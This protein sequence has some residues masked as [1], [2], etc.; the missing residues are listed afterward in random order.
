MSRRRSSGGYAMLAALLV[1]VLA[2]AFALVVV[3]AVHAVQSVEGADAAARRATAAEGPALAALARSLRWRPSA[4]SG[5]GEG[6]DPRTVGA[7]RVSWTPEPAVAGDAW[8]RVAAQVVTSAGRARHRDD[9]V[10]D[11]RS[12]SWAIGVTCAADADIAAPLTVCGSGVYLG[13]CLRGREN[14]AFVAG[15][16][17]GS[18]A[19]DVRGDLFPAAAVH[20]GAGIFAR[21][22]EIHE[23]PS[24]LGEFPDDSDRHAGRSVPETWLAGPAVE[25]LLAAAVE[26]ATP[27]RALRG[28]V[29]RLDQLTSAGSG[30]L[31]GGRCLLLPQTDEVV[32]EGSPPADAGRLL[33]IATG[34]AVLGSPGETVRLSGGIVVGGC[35]EV[36]GPLVLDGTL[37]AGSL[38]VEAPTDIHV[39]STWRETPLAGATLPTLV[40]HGG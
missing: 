11:L 34:D 10:F 8:P 17:T 7:W 40:A 19:D 16:G 23:D 26:A 15:A 24:V 5:A 38:R 3:G 20:G 22:V 36:R 32:I 29:L 39:A 14:V 1:G 13:G 31:T 25:F 30:E 35:L 21:G 9:L 28:G 18:P 2:A 27:G 37:H 4:L 6:G 33:V 12:E